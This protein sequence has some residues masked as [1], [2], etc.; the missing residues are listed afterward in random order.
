MRCIEKECYEYLKSYQGYWL[1]PD[2]G[3]LYKI[4]DLI[5]KIVRVHV[6]EEVTV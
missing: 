2:C 4:D 1:C 5:G 3:I 6:R